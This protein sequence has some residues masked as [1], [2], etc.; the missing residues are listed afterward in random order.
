MDVERERGVIARSN[1]S[2]AV[3]GLITYDSESGTRLQTRPRF[4]W[5]TISLLVL[6]RRR[7]LQLGQT[8][9]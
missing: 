6:R 3:G 8:V 1:R 4:A 9:T 5:I 2:L 7:L